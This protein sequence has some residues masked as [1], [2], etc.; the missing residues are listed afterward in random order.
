MDKQHEKQ[1][2]QQFALLCDEFPKGKLVA[3][4]SPDFVVKISTRRAIG[5]ELT[6]LKGQDFVNRTGKLIDPTE[7]IANIQDTIAAKVEKLYL[8]QRK[9]LFE[10]WLLIHVEA[11]K[12]EINFN[13]QNKLENLDFSS[14]FDRVFLLETRNN[15]FYE[16]D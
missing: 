7:I 16:L 6:G 5:I 1:I 9:K 10:I 8:Y 3:G 15:Q 12:S 11:L 14:G 4:E 2:L 13:F